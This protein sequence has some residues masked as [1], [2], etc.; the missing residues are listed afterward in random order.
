MPGRWMGGSPSLQLSLASSLPI[1]DP[2]WADLRL[3][4]VH[5]VH[6][7]CSRLSHSGDLDARID[8]HVLLTQ[9]GIRSPTCLLASNLLIGLCFDRASP[10]AAWTELRLDRASPLNC[11]TLN[12][13][14]LIPFLATCLSRALPP[15]AW[16]RMPPRLACLSRRAWRSS[17]RSPTP[18]TWGCEFL[19]GVNNLGLGDRMRENHILVRRW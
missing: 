6:C 17:S 7:P 4:D 14:T 13:G 18:R 19:T 11:G 16:T 5:G 12:C 10:P 15:A 1:V 2:L 8:A 3:P 9:F